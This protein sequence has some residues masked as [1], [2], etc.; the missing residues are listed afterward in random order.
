M[1]DLE[2]RDSQGKQKAIAI[3]SNIVAVGVERQKDVVKSALKRVIVDYLVEPRQFNIGAE[4]NKLLGY[5]PTKSADPV[6]IN[7]NAVGQI[8]KLTEIPKLY[9]NKLL[10]ELLGMQEMT[11]M[12]IARYVFNAHLHEGIYLDRKGKPAKFLH[13]IVNGEL[14]GFLSRN[15]NRKLGTVAMMR[16]FLEE[17]AKH[18]AKPV[19]ALHSTLKTALK[20]VSPVIYEPVDGEFV[21]FG[22]TYT[23]SDFGAGGLTVSGVILRISS[24]TTSV[25]GSNLRK[26]HLGSLIS[27]SD[28]ELSESTMDHESKAHQGAVRDM[29]A[30]VFSQD[31]IKKTLD[32]VKFAT[33]NRISWEK[34]TKQAKEVLS[35]AELE[36]LH[37]MLLDTK[38]EIIDLPPVTVDSLG[39]PEANAWWAAAALGRIADGTPDV[40]RKLEIQE[41]AG[42]LIG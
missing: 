1:T 34:L 39:D 42:G 12:A 18:D 14:C 8:C 4:N 33:E 22:A 31:N 17:C 24:G 28:I 36:K 15:Y 40:E 30:S 10:D 5:Y 35:K 7:N 6:H 29:V 26:I 16:P 25:L 23:N 37:A 21:A 11:R 38:N 3:L 27:D 19:D 41:L 2:A 20:C 32:L 13:R 9:V